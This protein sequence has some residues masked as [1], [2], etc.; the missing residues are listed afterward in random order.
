MVCVS[1]TEATAIRA[2]YDQDGELSAAIEL[3]VLPGCA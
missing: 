3:P 2:V 1:D